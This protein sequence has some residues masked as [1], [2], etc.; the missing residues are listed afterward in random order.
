MTRPRRID[1][2]LV[3]KAGDA[4]ACAKSLAEFRRAQAV[5]W[6]AVMGA[7][8]EQT[9][10]LLGVSRAA[11]PRWQARFGESVPA[12]PSPPG[13]GGRRRSLMTCDAEKE[14]LEPWAEQAKAGG[15][16]VVSVI[17]AAL[18][19]RLDRPVKPSVV[20]RLLERHGWRKVAPD[21]P[22]P[23]S[24]PAVQ[25]DWKKNFPRPWLPC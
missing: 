16:W 12:G 13:W 24:N 2:V 8:L 25:E 14:C 4:I 5:L 6:P 21:T 15:I 1:E 3:G 17:R 23:K 9:A 19:Q 10:A 7:T 20:S 18:A 22:H 11:V